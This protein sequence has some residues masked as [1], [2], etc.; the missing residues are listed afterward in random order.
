M[1]R[2][3]LRTVLA[4]GVAFVA[5]VALLVL[6]QGPG[7]LLGPFTAPSPEE[8]VDQV[9]TALKEENPYLALMEERRPQVFADLRAA[10]AEGAANGDTVIEMANDGR[11]VI[12][13]WLSEAI[14][15][16]PD[17]IALE[18]LAMTRAQFGE[19]LQS[20]P[21]MCAAMIKGKPFGDTEPYLS[22][23]ARARESDFYQALLTAP[24]QES[25]VILPQA[26]VDAAF[27]QIDPAL[28]ERF[29]SDLGLMQQASLS[30]EESAKVC[31]IRIATLELV[32]EMFTPERAA[33]MARALLGSR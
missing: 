27:R 28:A 32:E 22:D 26:E 18:L 24:A 9:L 5:V 19:L 23:A 31:E 7:G 3:R 6:S 20:N 15:T 4:V 29:G 11:Q 2:T 17:G 10:L 14:R 25:V 12:V 16:A 1:T 30:T 8:R 33:A 13:D 21:E